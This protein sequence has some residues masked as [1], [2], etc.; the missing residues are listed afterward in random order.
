[1]NIIQLKV[2]DIMKKHLKR[3]ILLLCCLV[4]ILGITTYFFIPKTKVIT[5]DGIIAA[6]DKTDL[7]NDASV[8]I[9]GTVNKLLPSEWSNPDFKKGENIRNIIQTDIVIDIDEVYKGTPYDSKSVTVRIEKG[10]VGNVEMKSEGFPDFIPGEEVILFLQEDDGDLLEPNE[11]YY[12]L[13]GMC[14][15]KFTLSESTDTEKIFKN[16]HDKDTLKLSSV[17]KEINDTLEYLK[18]NPLPRMTK[19]EIRKNNEKVLGKD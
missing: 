10:K 11:N 3:N 13:T 9:K 8:I 1:M 2:K 5:V 7:I 17:K 19:E 14:Q 4:F 12:R 6:K 15:G 18:K 16:A